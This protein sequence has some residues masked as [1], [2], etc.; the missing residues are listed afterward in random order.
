MP[1]LRKLLCARPEFACSRAGQTRGKRHEHLRQT[2]L[3]HFGPSEPAPSDLM[4]ARI[5]VPNLTRI[6]QR[7]EH[8]AKM[9]ERFTMVNTMKALPMPY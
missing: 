7:K 2:R 8:A 5:K 3:C 4:A 9:V 6:F 1:A